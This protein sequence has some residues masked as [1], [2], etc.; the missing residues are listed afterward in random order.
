MDQA[1]V[2]GLVVCYRAA[3]EP[4][5]NG[6]IATV[7]TGYWAENEQACTNLQFVSATAVVI[8]M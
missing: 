3:T 5:G 2:H 8:Y 4:H 6:K 7:C 1:V